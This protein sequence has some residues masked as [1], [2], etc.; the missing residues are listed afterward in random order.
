M[1]DIKSNY[2]LVIHVFACATIEKYKNEILK[3]NETWG[4]IAEQN[5]VKVLFFLGEELTDLIDP[6]KYIYLK[7]VS[8]DYESASHKQ[9]LGLKYIYENYNADFVFCCGSDTYINIKK[10]LLTINNYNKN[11][12]LY[13]GGDDIVYSI[14][15]ETI[16]YHSGGAGF[17][18]SNTALTYVYPLLNNMFDEWSNI[19]KINNKTYLIVACDACIAYYMIQIKSTTI[20]LANF[21]ACNYNGFA[22]TIRCCCHKIKINEIITCHYMSLQD[23][24][25]F[26]Q[27][28]IDNNYF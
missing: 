24:N 28:L 18:L 21:Y 7:D 16:T 5:G 8:N 22:G 25:D 3:I 11:D 17:I 6:E 2:K 23:C 4:K 13:I 26:T 14:N 27:K 1:S 9:N 20:T 19:C 15:N 12:N 10:M